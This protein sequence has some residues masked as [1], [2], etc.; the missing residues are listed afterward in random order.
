[1]TQALSSSSATSSSGS[2]GAVAPKPPSSAGLEGVVAAKSAVCF[3]DGVAGRLVYRGYEI[4]DLVEN[5][6]FEECAYLLWNE[7][8]PN[9]AELSEL[10]RQIA[11]NMALPQQ[12]GRASC[13]KECR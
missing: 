10:K 4:G 2:T 13:R 11:A 9:A 1:M 5:V 8:L 6:G 7:K 12:I 3:I